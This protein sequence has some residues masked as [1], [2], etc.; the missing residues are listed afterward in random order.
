MAP[1]LVTRRVSYAHSDAFAKAVAQAEYAK[2]SNARVRSGG[3]KGGG[4]LAQP[5]V[6]KLTDALSRRDAEAELRRPQKPEPAAKPDA[7]AGAKPAVAPGA[8]AA[9]D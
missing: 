3:E 8:G 7:K 2:L 9:K 4:E 5:V 6:E 1:H